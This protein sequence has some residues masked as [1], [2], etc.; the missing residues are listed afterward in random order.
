MLLW[1]IVTI[2]TAIA[3]AALYYAATRRSVNAAADDS[4]AT[5]RHFQAVLATIDADRAAG[6]LGDVEAEAAKGELAREIMLHKTENTDAEKGILFGGNAAFAA[7]LAVGVLALGTYQ[8]VGSPNMPSQPLAGRADAAAAIDIKQAVARI[9]TELASNPDDLRG[10]RVLAPVYMQSGRYADAA[11]AYRRIVDLGD[12][13]ANAQTDLGEALLMQAEGDASGEPMELFRKAVALD[14]SDVRARFYIAG[15]LTRT[16]DFP[17]AVSAWKELLA[18]SKGDE[19]W[20]PTANRG[21]KLAEADGVV[22]SAADTSAD[23]Q[24]AMIEGMVSGLAT[25]LTD[26]GGPIEEW[27]RLVR[28]YLVLGDKQAAQKTYDAAVKAYPKTFDRADLDSIAAA[29]ELT[30]EEPSHDIAIPN[31]KKGWTR[32]QKR[33]AVIA[34][35]AIVV[36]L[37]T[38]LVLVALRDQI[39]FFYTPSDLSA[40]DVAPGQA[41]RLGGLVKDGSWV[42]DGENNTFVI[43]DGGAEVKADFVGILPDLFRNGQG[44]VAEGSMTPQGDFAATNVLAKHDENYIPK[45]IVDSLKARGEWRPEAGAAN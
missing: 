35:L 44:V 29:G 18:L 2:V 12:M 4:A 1:F 5:N 11:K 36:G 34:G 15:E 22:D 16:G 31:Q 41:I 23:D 27:V 39:V 30:L 10:W 19:P 8:L 20:V 13:T 40:H 38:T 9:E 7:V 26:Q 17:A 37:A 24:A 33:L 42:R 32:K 43:T 25:R 6:K 21:L 28:S 45:E 3:C 14:P